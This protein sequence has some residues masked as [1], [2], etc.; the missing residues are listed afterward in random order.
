MTIANK[1][2]LNTLAAPAT[3]LFFQNFVI[4]V[5]CDL[6]TLFGRGPASMTASEQVAVSRTGQ[7]DN[8]E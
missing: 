4:M 3:L 5:C 8:E 6:L 7:L 1:H 2:T